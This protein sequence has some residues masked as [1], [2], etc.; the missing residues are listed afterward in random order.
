MTF[1]GELLGTAQNT[2]SQ[3]I[4][5]IEQWVTT[6]GRVV[7]QGVQLRVDNTCP[8]EIRYFSDPLCPSSDPTT[9]VVVGVTVTVIAVLVV[10]AVIA[11]V[12][13]FVAVRRH[14]H[15]AKPSR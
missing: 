2:S 4:S 10:L 13:I 6:D 7:V 1:R 8:V 3:L 14:K 15:R 11:A 5:Y 9:A 12:L